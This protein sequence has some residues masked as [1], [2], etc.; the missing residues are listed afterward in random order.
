MAERV[1]VVLEAQD[2]ASGVLRGLVSQFG[3]MGQAV[4]DASDALGKFSSFLD[5]AAQAQTDASVSAED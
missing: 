3:I 5:L 2:L 4:S 1:Q